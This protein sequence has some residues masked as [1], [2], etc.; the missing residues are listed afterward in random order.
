M[1]RGFYINH[2]INIS[3]RIKYS[4][5]KGDADKQKM[6]IPDNISP[7]LKYRL[8]VKPYG[9]ISVFL[10]SAN[11]IAS[12]PVSGLIS[13]DIFI[14]APAVVSCT[15]TASEIE[16]S[17]PQLSASLFQRTTSASLPS[18]SQTWQVVCSAPVTALFL[19]IDSDQRSDSLSSADPTRF[20]LGSVN[21]Q[22]RLGYYQVTLNDARVDGFP[23]QLYQTNSQTQ[24][25]IPQSSVMLKSGAFQ[26]W[27]R[28]G[29]LPAKGQQYSVQ[30]TIAPT[31]NS[32]QE[33]QGALVNGGE[34]NGEL[35]LAFPFNH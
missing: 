22:G 15:G 17:Y 11:A 28:D 8:R 9:F 24:V 33:T 32:L 6:T 20:G 27:T 10:F 1:W 13:E 25:G 4:Q 16:Y 29:H 21:G 23:V 3:D 30:L 2:Q 26:G 14:D 7:V 5:A 18:L 12:I 31:L 35:I 34:L 19:T